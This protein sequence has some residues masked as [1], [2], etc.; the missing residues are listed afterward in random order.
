[1]VFVVCWAIFSCPPLL[2]FVGSNGKNKAFFESRKDVGKPY[3]YTCF[4]TL[5][6]GR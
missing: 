1:M 3:V 5:D 4:Q 6:F 2:V